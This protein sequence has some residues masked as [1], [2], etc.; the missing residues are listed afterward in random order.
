MSVVVVHE[1]HEPGAVAGL[2]VL[3]HLLIACRVAEGRHSAPPDHQVDA[4]R[5][6]NLVVDQQH[7]G[8][9]GQSGLPVL[10]I[11]E[12]RVGG[13]PHDLLGRDAVDLLCVRGYE[14]LP[15]PVTK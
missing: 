10:V 11:P 4:D 6:A 13:R 3:E 15:P 8:H 1:H 5:L 12:L 14:I 9:L 7:L 2:G